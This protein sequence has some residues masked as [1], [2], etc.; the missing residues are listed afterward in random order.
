MISSGCSTST[1]QP[2]EICCHDT[3]FE[4]IWVSRLHEIR[5]TCFVSS[6]FP[7]FSIDSS[8][9]L[10]RSWDCILNILH[11]INY[12]I[13]LMLNA[14]WLVSVDPRVCKYWSSKFWQLIYPHSESVKLVSAGSNTLGQKMR[15]QVSHI[16]QEFVCQSQAE[17]LQRKA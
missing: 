8:L 13:Q 9:L 3:N 15:V 16:T 11:R 17:L 6:F 2:P 14:S 1:L 12:I 10:N 4:A 7:T 5:Q